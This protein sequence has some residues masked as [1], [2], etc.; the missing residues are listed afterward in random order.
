MASGRSIRHTE[1]H[2]RLREG[3]VHS[4]GADIFNNSVNIRRHRDVIISSYDT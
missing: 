4:G 1:V 3:V 2:G